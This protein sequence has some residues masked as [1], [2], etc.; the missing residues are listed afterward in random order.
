MT[1]F[2]RPGSW[3]QDLAATLLIVAVAVL[4]RLLFLAADPPQDFAYGWLADEG[5][6]AH[7]ARQHFLFGRWVLDEANPGLFAAPL[8]TVALEGWYR[9]VGLGLAE[10]RMLSALA[11]VLTCVVFY[12]GLRA[13]L[14]IGRALPPALVLAVSYLLLTHNRVGLTESLQLLCV[15]GMVACLFHAFRRPVL[16]PVAG[17]CFVLALLAKPSAAV[18]GLVLAIFWLTHWLR[19]RRGWPGPAFAWRQPLW[20]GAVVLVAGAVLGLLV[21]L[22]NW[23]AISQQMGIS[24]L[25]VYGAEAHAAARRVPLLG[26]DAFGFVVDGFFVQCATLLLPAVLFAVARLGRAVRQRMDVEE[27][28]CWIWLGAGLLFLASQRYQPERRF[29]LLLPPLAFLASAAV[30]VTGLRLPARSALLARG[31]RWR[32]LTLGALAGL[33]TGLYLQALVFLPRWGVMPGD[34]ARRSAAAALLVA[35]AIIAGALAARL[36]AQRFPLRPM[37]LPAWPFIALFLISDPLRFADYLRQPQFAA[38]TAIEQFRDFTRSLPLADRVVV[39]TSA[40]GLALE[41]RV[42]AFS[43]RYRPGPG[44]YLNLD[45]WERFNPA[46]AVVVAPPGKP[47]WDLEQQRILAEARRRGMTPVAWYVTRYDRQGH[48]SYVATVYGRAAVRNLPAQ[49]AGR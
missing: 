5:A 39:G 41:S 21:I 35:L 34:P 36:A 31:G 30:Q 9:L 33:V 40:D 19:S 25:N 17:L 29:L 49:P 3:R 18:M 8:Y 47:P 22:P 13:R 43:I 38:A 12:A 44:S 10:T 4:P 42:Q 20:F 2:R 32:A 16:W 28:F 1:E 45:G 37:V 14:P 27:L 26:W 24:L 23:D 11:G 48:A 6:W 46:L 7:N 15:T